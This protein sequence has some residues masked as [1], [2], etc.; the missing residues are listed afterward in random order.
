MGFKTCSK[1]KST[2]DSKNS[3]KSLGTESSKNRSLIWIFFYWMTVK[4]LNPP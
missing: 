1:F 2:F 3:L 4:K